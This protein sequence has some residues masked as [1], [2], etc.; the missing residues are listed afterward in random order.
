MKTIT[1]SGTTV[2]SKTPRDIKKTVFLAEDD[3][4]DH[5]LIKAAFEVVDPSVEIVSFYS[6]DALVE[7]LK[8]KRTKLDL[9]SPC[10]IL[11]DLNMPN[12]DGFETLS[13]IKTMPESCALPVIIYTTSRSDF[14]FQQAYQLGASSYIVKPSQY[15]VIERVMRAISV[16]WFDTVLVNSL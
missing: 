5:Y 16:Y 3:P 8:E 15:S 14:D 12:C 9:A 2:D 4:D 7:H 6:G 13:M 11:L 1:D 10:I